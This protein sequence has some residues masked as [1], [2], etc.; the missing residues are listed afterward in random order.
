MPD[1]VVTLDGDACRRIVTGLRDDDA[2]VRV[3]HE[4]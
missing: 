2:A 1:L 4:D 3:T